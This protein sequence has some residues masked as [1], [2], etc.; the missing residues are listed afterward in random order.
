MDLN[1]NK[2]AERAYEL[3]RAQDAK[4]PEWGALPN[5]HYWFDTVRTFIHFPK[6]KPVGAAEE[7]IVAAIAEARE[8]AS[9]PVAPVVAKPVDAVTVALEPETPAEVATEKASAK[10]TPATPAKPSTKKK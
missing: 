10:K 5:Q 4:A 1:Y 7:C 3:F 8:A 2:L 6:G 9:W